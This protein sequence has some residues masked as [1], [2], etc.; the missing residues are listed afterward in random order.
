MKD[1][2]FFIIHFGASI[3]WGYYCCKFQTEYLI[4][5][6]SSKHKPFPNSDYT[7]TTII[8]RVYPV[9]CNRDYEKLKIP[10]N[11]VLNTLNRN[12]DFQHFLV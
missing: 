11:E 12:S 3:V 1:P 8:T 10:G 9:G 7:R 5:P 2:I 4:F 6:Y